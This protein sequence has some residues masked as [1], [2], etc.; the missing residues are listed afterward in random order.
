MYLPEASIIQ[1]KHNG[2]NRHRTTRATVQSYVKLQEA[3]PKHQAGIHQANTDLVV[4]FAFVFMKRWRS[5]PPLPPPKKKVNHAVE[6]QP[7]SM[8]SFG[9]QCA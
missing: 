3:T 6:G 8:R 4:G 5:E 1:K 2:R 9:P 7:L